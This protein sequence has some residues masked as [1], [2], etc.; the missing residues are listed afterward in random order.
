MIR[1]LTA[2]FL[3]VTTVS[4]QAQP[5]LK[6]VSLNGST[7]EILFALGLGEQ[8]VG[9][10]TSSSYPALAQKINKVGYQRTL[11]SEGILSFSPSHLIGTVTAGPPS[12]IEQLKLLSLPM[13]IVPEVNSPDGVENKI[14]L[15]SNF[16][17]KQKEGENLLKEFKLKMKSFQKPKLQKEVKVLF[18][19]SRNAS[20]IFVSGTN[21]PAASMIELSGA[22]NAVGDF[23]DYKPL[24]SESLVS[25]N[26]DV[27]LIT[28]HSYDMLG[29]G[30]ALWDIPGILTTKAGMN[31]SYIVMDDLLLL[32]FG[33]RLPDALKELGNKW[34]MID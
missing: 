26:P 1:T 30:K 24:T 14:K 21:T 31:K 10:D 20:S 17:G 32:G 3:C 18:L 6:I 9:V 5:K 28:K 13:L 33:P 12:T 15:I 8:I 4:L 2:F 7:T 34:K 27:I 19:Y 29:G 25:A 16:V 11:T 23:T 22:V